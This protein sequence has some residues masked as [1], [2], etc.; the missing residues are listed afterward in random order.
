MSRAAVEVQS[1]VVGVA[2]MQQLPLR[3]APDEQCVAGFSRAMTATGASTSRC[4]SL[5]GVM[6]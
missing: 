6:Q 1:T 2:V 5:R 3:A 4:S